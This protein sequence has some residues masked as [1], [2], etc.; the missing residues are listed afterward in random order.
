MFEKSTPAGCCGMPGLLEALEGETT[1][2]RQA[3][4]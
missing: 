2:T 1:V 4:L 3:V